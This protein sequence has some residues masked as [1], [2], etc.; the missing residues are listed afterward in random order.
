MRRLLSGLL[1]IWVGACASATWTES[2][3]DDDMVAPARLGVAE[4]QVSFWRPGV[5][6][7]QPARVNTEIGRAHV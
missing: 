6:N 5:D 2:D 3:G 4:G 7:W 1:L